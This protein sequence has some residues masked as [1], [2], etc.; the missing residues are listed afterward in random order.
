MGLR[1]EDLDISGLCGSAL[2]PFPSRLQ[3]RGGAVKF[4]RRILVIICCVGIQQEEMNP[5]NSTGQE[6]SSAGEQQPR[7]DTEASLPLQAAGVSSSANNQQLANVEGQAS[8]NLNAATATSAVARSASA[9]SPPDATIANLLAAQGTQGLELSALRQQLI[10]SGTQPLSAF[11]L[12]QLNMQRE[13]QQQEQ[14]LQFLLGLQQQDEQANFLSA[15]IQSGNVQGQQY[16]DTDS[17]RRVLEQQSLLRVSQLRRELALSSALAGVAT[18]PSFHALREGLSSPP[19]ATQSFLAQQL[20]ALQQQGGFTD[21]N[22]AM[23]QSALQRLQE[24]GLPS[25]GEPVSGAVTEGTLSVIQQL[26]LQQQLSR[27][28]GTGGADSATFPGFSAGNQQG[29]HGSIASS[30]PSLEHALAAAGLPGSTG[31]L[32]VAASR[33]QQADR[34]TEDTKYSEASLLDD[35]SRRRRS[36]KHES[37]PSKLYRILEEAEANGQGNIISFT[38]SGAA[39]RIHRPKDFAQ[40]IVPKYFRHNHLSSFKRLLRMYGFRKVTSGIDKGAF[41]HASFLRGRP[42]L[43]SEI[44]RVRDKDSGASRGEDSGDEKAGG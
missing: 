10:N 4:S 37:F 25:A 44:T 2:R 41:A 24:T 27:G 40:H 38:P 6:S 13:R 7:R 8:S 23:A 9:P 39:I 36:L 1:V 11:Q 16:R 34:T 43:T 22:N 19:A 12:A 32:S 20:G 30:V 35:A 26:I 42:E 15:L 29:P 17:I 33:P 28:A 5:S 18:S 21:A 31:L 14:Q 3:N